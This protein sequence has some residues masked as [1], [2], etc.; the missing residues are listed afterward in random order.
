[1]FALGMIV[2]LLILCL[3]TYDERPAKI[4]RTVVH[5]D[6]WKFDRKGINKTPKQG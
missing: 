1:M 3:L 4:K 2:T 5:P 6:Y